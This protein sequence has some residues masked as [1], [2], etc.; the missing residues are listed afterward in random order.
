MR[1]IGRDSMRLTS[2]SLAQLLI[3][4][5]LWGQGATVTAQAPAMNSASTSQPP[6]TTTASTSTK[7]VP[8][9]VLD[10][11]V[12]EFDLMKKK[13]PGSERQFATSP[14][15]YIPYLVA[16]TAT[17]QLFNA[18]QEQRV[19]VQVTSSQSAGSSTS[20]TNKG[21]VP[22]LFG[23]A[24]ED[25]A[26]TQST[27]NGQIVLRGN[28]ANAISAIKFHDYITSFDK[29]QEQ[30]ALVR[31]IAATSFSISFNPSS[32]TNSAASPTPQTNNF[33]GFSVHYDIYNHR[34]PRDQRWRTSWA[35]TVVDLTSASNSALA[36]LD[37]LDK[38]LRLKGALIDIAP[39]FGSKGARYLSGGTIAGTIGQTCTLADFDGVPG[40]EASVVLTSNNT[41]APGTPLTITKQGRG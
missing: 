22:W 7:S 17:T 15:T 31:N 1:R 37:A 13:A 6:S 33:S 19:D 21:S 24:V 41:I 10:Q 36:F 9:Q 34:D 30:N 20:T 39:P 3:L 5:A 28:V 14:T 32:T 11:L 12:K 38:F 29:I 16:P 25:G 2:L 18:F 23:L 26:L 35:S 4:V 8:D 27:T 40:V